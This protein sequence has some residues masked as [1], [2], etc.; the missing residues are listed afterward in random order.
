MQAQIID[1][2]LGAKLVG[3]D[4]VFAKDMI[5]TLVEGFPS[6]LKKLETAYAK[7]DWATIK[8][9]VHRVKGGVSYC[10]APRLQKISATLLD[11]LHSAKTDD[12]E[13]LYQDF[14]SEIHAVEDAYKSL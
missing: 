11:Y 13:K 1:L 10:G 9:V 3:K 8:D 4:T 7:Q 6:E 5:T 14:L 12:R 2:N